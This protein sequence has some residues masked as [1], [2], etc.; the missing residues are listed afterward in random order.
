V[1]RRCLSSEEEAGQER[2]LSELKKHGR[3]TLFPKKGAGD[4]PTVNQDRT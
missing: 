2:F 1:I 4:Q 3:R